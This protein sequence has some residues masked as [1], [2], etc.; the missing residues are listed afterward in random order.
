ME[1]KPNSTLPIIFVFV[2]NILNIGNILY[3]L[4]QYGDLPNKLNQLDADEETEFKSTLFYVFVIFCIWNVL[5]LSGYK[6]GHQGV[7]IVHSLCLCLATLVF[8]G[9]LVKKVCTEFERKWVLYLISSGEGLIASVFGLYYSQM[10]INFNWGNYQEINLTESLISGKC[11]NCLRET[12][13]VVSFSNEGILL[14]YY[15]VLNVKI[16]PKKQIL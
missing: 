6:V 11:A 13:Q 3:I 16:L 8:S 9:F 15:C 7:I 4:I 12:N 14:C 5:G 2:H 10:I 1:H